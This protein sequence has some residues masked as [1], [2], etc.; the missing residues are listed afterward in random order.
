MRAI[1]I[2][3][4]HPQAR[5]IGAVRLR[6]FAQALAARGHQIVLLTGPVGAPAPIDPVIPARLAAD[7]A[8][9]DWSRPFTLSCP[10]NALPGLDALRSG[11]L[12]RPLRMVMIGGL[13]LA[14][15]GVFPDWTAATQPLW[16]VLAKEFQPQITWGTFGNTDA[17]TI[18]RGIA[19]ASACPWGMDIKDCWTAFMPRPLRAI[20][21]AKFQD[22]AAKTALSQGHL[23][24]TGAWFPGQ[25]AIIHS[26]LPRHLVEAGAAPLARLPWRIVLSG[27][28]YCAEQLAS[29]VTAVRQWRQAAGPDGADAIF[30]YAGGDHREVAAAAAALDGI[31]AVEIHPFL[32][33]EGLFA[34]QR[35]AAVNLYVKNA[36][37]PDWFHHKV[38]ELFATGR[39]AASLPP[40]GAEAQALAARLGAR[41][42]GA[43]DAAGL[44]KILAECWASRRADPDSIDRTAL[45][46][47]CWDAQAEK[48]EQVLGEAASCG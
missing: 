3:H 8:S 25:G 45:A 6:E 2:N 19:R 15:G 17:W 1:F 34:L 48:L 26:G 30:T 44:E 33:L 41:L 39:P 14:T 28:T 46:G 7:L 29:I 37:A 32:P 23:D 5:H 16:P 43:R 36:A 27:G 13:Y 10:H 40:D 31:M 22:A 47:F 12:P 9:H 20:V 35:E 11:R 42:L 38:F 21:A 18:A 24:D 4:Y